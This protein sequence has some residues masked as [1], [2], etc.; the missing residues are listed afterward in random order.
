MDV[1]IPAT[2][3]AVAA[4][5][6][7]RVDDDD[8]DPPGR[9]SFR[10]SSYLL[11]AVEVAI[12][13]VWNAA[14]V[15]PPTCAVSCRANPCTCTATYAVGRVTASRYRAQINEKTTMPDAKPHRRHR[16]L[17]V[18]VVAV[19]AS[20]LDSTS[21]VSSGTWDDDEG[22]PP[23]G[24]AGLLLLLLVLRCG[25][26]FG[27]GGPSAKNAEAAAGEDDLVARAGA[28]KEE[29]EEEAAMGDRLALGGWGRAIAFSGS[30][31]RQRRQAGRQ[32]R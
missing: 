14:A 23:A 16:R 9:S 29:E 20:S 12:L 21:S 4:F 32:G 27:G 3:A 18:V 8:E 24:V 25:S 30:A 15:A 22:L 5:D 10:L 19:V 6:G 26:Q 28:E 11:L 13:V 17:V 7:C 2:A 31:G 1:P